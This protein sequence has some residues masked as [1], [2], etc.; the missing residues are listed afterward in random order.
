[1]RR[2]KEGG[3][4]G[5]CFLSMVVRGEEGHGAGPDS[6]QDAYSRDREGSDLHWV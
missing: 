3:R 6:F 4:R 1:M 5:G 2:R